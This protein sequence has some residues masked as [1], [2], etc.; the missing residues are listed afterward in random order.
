MADS[1]DSGAISIWLQSLPEN[2]R[3]RLWQGAEALAAF[4]GQSVRSVLDQA[5]RIKIESGQ[6]AC[7]ELVE[8]LSCLGKHQNAKPV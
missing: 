3:T 6:S 8:A 1:W 7:S 5:Y 4:S 2:E